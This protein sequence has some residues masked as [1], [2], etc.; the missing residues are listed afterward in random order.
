MQL[1]R[2]L[3]RGSDVSKSADRIEVNGIPAI[4]VK[5]A[6]E[7]GLLFCT[8]SPHKNGHNYEILGKIPDATYLT[9]YDQFE[10]HID[11]IC[12]KYGIP[13]LDGVDGNKPT[14]TMTDL[15]KEDTV[16]LEGHNRHEGILRYI[17]SLLWN[18]PMAPLGD[19]KQ[20]AMIKNERL[21]KPPLD[22]TE[23]EKQFDGKHK[24]PSVHNEEK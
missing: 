9:V 7:H 15:Y 19:I 11:S 10:Q 6:G 4:E 24:R 21:C 3:R 14:L 17:E 16:I 1:I 5:G 18:N 2:S 23:F 13:Y 20:W 12:R 8:P 22:K